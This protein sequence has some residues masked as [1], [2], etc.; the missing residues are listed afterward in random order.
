MSSEPALPAVP[1]TSVA[2]TDGA[3]DP[4]NAGE[5]ME[6]AKFI[7]A[8]NLKPKG[9]NTAADCFLVMLYGQAYGFH[10]AEALQSLHV[11]H[12]KVAAGGETLAGLIQSHP[13]CKDYRTWVEGEGEERGQPL[14]G[15]ERPETAR[16]LLRVWR[17]ERGGH[18]PLRPLP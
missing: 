15:R 13:L 10:P 6:M 8:S 4:R 9:L 3:L 17:S 14:A 2:I 12:G 1:R 16:L 7:A 18:R 5:L 11:V